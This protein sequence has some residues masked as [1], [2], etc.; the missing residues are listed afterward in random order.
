VVNTYVLVNGFKESKH[1]IIQESVSEEDLA[2][3]T[4]EEIDYYVKFRDYERVKQYERVIHSV[5]ADVPIY[6]KIYFQHSDGVFSLPN[7]LK[8]KPF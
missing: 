8:M 6:G 7:E 1:R 2:H 3:M 5:A 4:R